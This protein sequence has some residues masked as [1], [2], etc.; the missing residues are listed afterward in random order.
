[1]NHLY[2]SL[3]SSS[4]PPTPRNERECSQKKAADEPSLLVKVTAAQLRRIGCNE[5]YHSERLEAR[6]LST[7]LIDRYGLNSHPLPTFPEPSPISG[8]QFEQFLIQINNNDPL[9]EFLEVRSFPE[10][11]Q[12]DQHL[13][14]FCDKQNGVDIRLCKLP[15]ILSSVESLIKE[16]N[17]RHI[18]RFDG[19]GWA[20][21]AGLEV[22]DLLLSSGHT[23]LAT[24]VSNDDMSFHIHTSQNKTLEPICFFHRSDV[25]HLTICTPLVVKQSI[26]II[27][28]TN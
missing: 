26:G 9:L 5:G 10:L 25:S 1:M 28:T 23:H 19:A 17:Y 22:G 15:N 7:Y 21:S 8:D 11:H 14:R 12:P 4:P 18:S 13:T 27:V 3:P 2:A 6:K 20:R 24:S 16:N